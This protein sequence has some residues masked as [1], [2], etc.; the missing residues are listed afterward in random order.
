MRIG[1][2]VTA[3]AVAL[4]GCAKDATQVGATYIS[5]ITYQGY[6]CAQLGEEATR[7]SERAAS[8][9][10]VQNQKSTNDAIGM[11]VGLV[12]FWP[13]LFMIKGNDETT[14]ELARLKG[15]M[16][17][18]EVVS[19]QKKCGIVFQRPKPPEPAPPGPAGT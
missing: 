6:T 16:D 18:I 11:T 17:A 10:G 7:V 8:A 12:V 14:A 13:A 1:L 4:G 5:P 19:I 2:V 15:Q 9:T 3:L